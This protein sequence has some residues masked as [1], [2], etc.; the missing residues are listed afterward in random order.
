MTGLRLRRWWAALALLGLV[1][2]QALAAER[3]TLRLADQKGGMRSQL[4]AAG[5]LDGLGYDIQWFEFPAAAPLGE[6]LNAGAVDAG[7]IGDAPL[8]FVLA[9]G[10]RVKAIAVDK[11]DPWGTAVLVPQGSPLQSAADLKGKRIAT[12]RGSIGHYIAL[13]A[14]AS[15]GLNDKDVQ[16]RFLGPVDAKVALANGS[17]DAWATWEPYTTLAEQ[18]DKARVLVNGR[19]LSAGNT[20]LAAT[21]DAL[22]DPAR[23]A[24]LQDYLQRLARSQVWAYEHLGEYSQVLA[25]LIGFPEPVA[26]LQF[27]RRKL[28]WQGLDEATA[29]DQQSTADFYHS[30]GLIP[31]KLDVAPTFDNSF[32][33]QAAP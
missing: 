16:F 9:A 26:R 29:R 8:L 14:L 10:A 24:A 7:I 20:F 33:L 25:K 27:E 19:G 22:A 30:S 17:V 6:A 28:Q 11:S 13:K 12:G 18:V 3:V 5:A 15:V 2:G 21:D 31:Q 23:R 4:E 1:A 32:T